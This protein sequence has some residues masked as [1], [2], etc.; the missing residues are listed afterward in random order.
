MSQIAVECIGLSKYYGDVLAVQNLNLTVHK[1]EILALVGP[2]GCGKTTLLRMIAG[3]ERP[4][5]GKVVLQGQVVANGARFIPP[6]QRGV[7]MVFQDYALFPHLTVAQNVGFGLNGRPGKGASIAAHLEMVGLNGYAS[8]YPHELSGG[9]RQRVA[10]ARALAPQPVLVLLD[11]PFS[12]LD[13]DR[14]G[15]VREEVRLILKDADATAVFVTHDQEE[16]L[17]IGDRLAVLNQGWLAQIGVAEEIFH[18]PAT[19]FV[20]EFM[21]QTNFLPG[22]VTRAGILTEIG[23]IPQKIPLPIGEMVEV[24]LRPDDVDFAPQAGA[25]ATIQA[26]HFKGAM[27]VYRL[28]LPSGRLLH[29]HQP[30]TRILTV[31]ASVNVVANP[32]HELSWFCLDKGVAA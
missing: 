7:G 16:A 24:V 2:S 14:R 28:C 8:R 10:L 5:A 23:L 11:E 12:N 9:E 18:R 1:G 27:N 32:G 19:R 31:G 15:Q 25:C 4:D 17:T 3:F 30:H 20:A 26:R 21:G 6:E 22:E 29:S 13:A